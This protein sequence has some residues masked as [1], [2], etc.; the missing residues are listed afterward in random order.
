MRTGTLSD[1]ADI[2]NGKTPS[3][4]EQRSV[5]FPVLKIKDIDENGQ[6]RGEFESFVDNSL[7]NKFHEKV[8]KEFDVLLLNAAHNS[9]YVGSKNCIVTKE[10]SGS[11]ATGEWSVIRTKYDKAEPKYIYF[12]INSLYGKREIRS[13]VKGIHLYPKDL[14]R[15]KITIPSVSEQKEI[16]K[17]LDQAD[18]LRQKR[19]QAIDLLD[20]YIKSVFLEMFGDPVANPKGWKKVKLKDLCTEIA[21]IDHN[22]PKATEDGYPFISAKDLMDDGTISFENIKYI[23]EKDFLR[24]SR[25]I[26]PQKGDII[27]SRI[28]AKLGKARIVE[29]DFDFLASYSCCTIRPIDTKINKVF[30]NHVLNTPSLLR[31]AHNDVRA[32]GVPD[33]GMDKIRAFEIIVPPVN[34]QLKFVELASNAKNLKQKMLMQS[35]ELDNQFQALMQK[36]FNS[37]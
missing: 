11:L 28:G 21:D 20:E 14:N 16:V 8:T 15:L 3:K 9:D 29:V 32:I 25:K 33:L 35:G 4:I 31:Q 12:Y 19:K 7:A 26:K 10:F 1:V 23:S 36:S 18:A 2:F 37:N 22:M 34:L 17:I 27:Y 24:L 5:G 30:L 6:F 13:I